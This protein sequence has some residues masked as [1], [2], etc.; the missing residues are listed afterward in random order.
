M[1][2]IARKEIAVKILLNGRFIHH[3]NE[4]HELIITVS[5]HLF[6]SKVQKSSIPVSTSVDP[7]FM[8]FRYDFFSETISFSGGFLKRITGKMCITYS[9]EDV[10][11]NKT[12]LKFDK[13]KIV[14]AIEKIKKG[15]KLKYTFRAIAKGNTSY[16][17]KVEYD[18]VQ[19]IEGK[20]TAV[21]GRVYDISEQQA[22]KEFYDKAISL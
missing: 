13:Q 19:N 3:L 18:F 15:K 14:Q 8:S 12:A 6:T 17:V 5:P 22:A 21:V 10:Y 9:I 20:N 2:N 16:W 1:S 4:I 11:N 7:H